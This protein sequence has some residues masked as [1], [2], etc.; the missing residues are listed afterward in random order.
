MMYK[1]SIS[2]VAICFLVG[3]IAL[4][5]RSATPFE[6][7]ATEKP[8]L[9]DAVSPEDVTVDYLPQWDT[10]EVLGNPHK[11]WYHHYYDNGTGIYRIGG[12]GIGP[13]DANLPEEFNLIKT[14]PGMD[15]LY[16][17]LAWSY[18]EPKEG[19]FDWHL[20]DEVV[21]KYVPLGFG[22]SFRITCRE[23][24]GYPGSVNEQGSDGL[25]YST[26]KWVRD[27]GAKGTVIPL[28][29]TVGSVPSW[30]P[31]YDDP[32][33]LAK[34][35]NFHVAFAAR[36]D[37][38][39]YV[40]Y[41]DIGSV[42]DWGEGH[43]HFSV[44]KEVPNSVLKK[45]VDLYVK[46]YKKT[47]LYMVEGFVVYK[48]E[49]LGEGHYITAPAPK[50][51]EIY[52]YAKSKG[53]AFRS[54]AFMVDYYMQIA[55]DRWSVTRPYLFE[56]MYLTKPI[57][58][59]LEHY[60]EGQEMG[61]FSGLN[62]SD[63]NRYGYSGATFMEKSMEL[64][65]P[66]YIGFHG[67]VKDWLNDNPA[68]SNH[69][70]NRC[71]YWYFIK[72][73][74]YSPVLKYISNKLTLTWLNKGVAP[75]YNRYALIL[76]FVGSQISFNV[77]ITDSGN[78]RWMPNGQYYTHEYEYDIPSGIPPGMYNLS[79]KLYDKESTTKTVQVALKKNDLLDD[80]FIKVGEVKL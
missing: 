39:P 59:E 55:T 13:G 26:P 8:N 5:C 21:N 51:K 50:V 66:T 6:E 63:V 15:H 11:G 4:T 36:Y 23:T 31:D 79:L 41:I 25:C 47:Q 7:T 45:H 80:E 64:S 65:H 60:K 72:D 77:E 56:Q 3:I 44:Q 58:Y 20:I 2:I 29:N 9:S 24:G 54:D 27:A 46:H 35:D 43:T 61:H 57:V 16:I 75:A 32:I 1:S 12:D 49:P 33:F 38:R 67:Y 78:L 71:G 70:A 48:K 30:A 40:R 28:G 34:L 14:F 53:V 74:K 62:S 10:I 37:G 42:G 22:I 69:L 73:A 52:D 76:H 18:L 68:L 17:R 19:Q